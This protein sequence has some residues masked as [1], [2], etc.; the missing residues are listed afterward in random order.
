[1]LTM[2]F[3][4][5]L[6]NL[7][8][9]P[10]A[11]A[12][13][14]YAQRI[15]EAGYY[16]LFVGD[17]IALPVQPETRYVGSSTGVA[18]F[19]SQHDIYESFTLLAYLAG[20]TRRLRLGIAVQVLPYRPPLLNAKMVTTLDVLSGGRVILGVGTGWCREE[21]TA[22]DA[23][24]EQR[25]SVPDEHTQLLKA[26]CTGEELNFHGK[27]YHVEGTRILPRP[28]QLPNP[29]IWVGG[30][31]PPAI[32]RA[33]LLG[34]GWHPIRLT[35]EELAEKRQRLLDMRQAHKLPVEGFPTA[36]GIPMHLGDKP[37]P[38]AYRVALQ[39]S[40]ADMASQA[41][42]YADAGVD[43]FI[44]RSTETDFTSYLKAM[45]QFAEQ[46]IPLLA[47]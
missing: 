40:P 5:M 13:E 17:H 11:Q 1:M 25:G 3:A 8:G 20:I 4:A 15:E 19:T 36:L 28:L 34:D 38:T 22:L 35:P 27:H 24:F 41:Q 47:P 45:E 7:G 14:P 44:L 33:A 10:N 37:L 18:E 9:I 30:D 46:V 26:V 2:R 6:P 12:I 31:S 39:G 42:A 23:N 29:P 16:G 43:T 32:R 21:F